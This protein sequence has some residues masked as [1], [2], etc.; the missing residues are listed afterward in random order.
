[1]ASVT[2]QSQQDAVS[3]GIENFELPRSLVTKLAR[4]GMSDNMK[5][6]KDVVLSFQKASTVF[7]NYLAATAHEVAT[8]KQHKSISAS[9]V[10]K[11]LEMVGMGDVVPKLQDELNVYRELQ[12]NGGRKSSSAKGKA[13]EALPESASTAQVKG[14]GKER[15]KGP[16]ITIGPLHPR[17]SIATTA[18]L[19]ADAEMDGTDA[20]LRDEEMLESEGDPE[21]D[22][23]EELEDNEGEVE[24]IENTMAIEGDEVAR[25]ALGLDKSAEE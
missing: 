22:V 4:S 18:E 17:T 21:E 24:E 7:V 19:D 3:E 15:E 9:D 25:D 2:A 6:Q 1:M 23:E 10:L 16:T 12:K 11:A 14:K 13:R 5:M 20:P 8:S